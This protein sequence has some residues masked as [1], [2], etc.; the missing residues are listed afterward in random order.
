VADRRFVTVR[1]LL[2]L[3]LFPACS[4]S[5]T[6]TDHCELRRETPQ[7]AII[8]VPGDRSIL[9][10]LPQGLVPSGSWVTIRIGRR[11]WQVRALDDAVEL[12]GMANPF[13]DS[14]SLTLIAGRK[15][16]L[17]F[18]LDGS[19]S[20]WTKLRDCESPVRGGGWISLSGEITPLTDDRIMRAIRYLRPHGVLLDSIGGSALEAMRV[21]FTIRSEGIATK[22]ESNSQCLSEC[23]FILAAGTPRVVDDG[24]R[25][26][27]PT[28]L[29][30][31]GLGVFEH[32]Q[33]K[34]SDSATYFGY[35]GIDSRRLAVLSTGA[36]TDGVRALTP[37]ELREVRLAD[38]PLPDRKPA[39]S[40]TQPPDFEDGDWLLLVGLIGFFLLGWVLMRYRGRA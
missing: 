5:W 14:E 10:L 15:E 18:S 8:V 31:R 28:S 12:A 7:G 33:E 29:I 11:N 4:W 34:L 38:N 40:P 35:M 21:G 30:T 3:F 24:A 17:T 36:E 27:I 39:V 13:L 1:G 26:G 23:T 16:L 20:A 6:L 37:A 9:L 2:L 19:S 25:V 32:A 22:V